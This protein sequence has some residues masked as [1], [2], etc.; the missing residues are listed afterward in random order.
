MNM[1]TVVVATSH[2]LSVSRVSPD[3]LWFSKLDHQPCR[4]GNRTNKN[5]EGLYVV[6][7]STMKLGTI[8]NAGA[9]M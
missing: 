5:I 6:V 9:M 4:T 7:M 2:V 3:L 1:L 8:A